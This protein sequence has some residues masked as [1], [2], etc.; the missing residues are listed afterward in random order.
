MR[1]AT[2]QDLSMRRDMLPSFVVV[3]EAS[4]IHPWLRCCQTGLRFAPKAMRPCG[5]QHWGCSSGL[6]F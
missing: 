6:A 5:F 2:V 4:S 1:L 3:L